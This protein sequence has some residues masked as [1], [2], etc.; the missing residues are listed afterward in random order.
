[1]LFRYDWHGK[2]RPVLANFAYRVYGSR[3]FPPPRS[4]L[5]PE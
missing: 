3:H 4:G 1:M 5:I 2:K